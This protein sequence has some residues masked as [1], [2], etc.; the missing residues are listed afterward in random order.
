[1]SAEER[2]EAARLLDAAVALVS[3]S[4]AEDERN[5]DMEHNWFEVPREAI[6][7]HR[8]LTGDSQAAFN[9]V[10]AVLGKDPALK[11]VRLKVKGDFLIG[12]AW[13]ARG[14]G[15][16]GWYWSGQCCSW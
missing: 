5:P 15:F 1:M 3:K 8:Q 2:K 14:S 12:Y 4:V 11:A 6:R 10:D 7:G 9:R 16:A 13:E